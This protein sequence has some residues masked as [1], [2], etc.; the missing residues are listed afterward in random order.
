MTII[1][2]FRNKN[3]WLTAS[4]IDVLTR[5]DE[6]NENL[7]LSDS[8]RNVQLYRCVQF[9]KETDKDF[10]DASEQDLRQV[11]RTKNARAT[12]EN[13]KTFFKKFWTWYGKPELIAWI[14]FA[15]NVGNKKRPEDMLSEAEVQKIIDSCLCF[16]D[17]TMN[18]S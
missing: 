9:L 10:G 2:F 18:F 13:W 5:F 12:K 3:P 16:R 7:G 6:E 8:T 17:K 1:E 15:K 14:K 4:A 11:I